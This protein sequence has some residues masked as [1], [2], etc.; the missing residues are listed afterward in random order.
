MGWV[1]RKGGRYYYANERIGDRVITT[2][3]GAGERAEAV[4][5]LLEQERIERELARAQDLAEVER[6]RAEDCELN[7]IDDLVVDLTKGA[8]L[9]AGYHQHRGQWRKMRNGKK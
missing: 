1:T 4:A 5:S 8:L 9:D 3:H 6:M 2:Y 7:I